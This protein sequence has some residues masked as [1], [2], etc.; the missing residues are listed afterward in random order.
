[1][2]GNVNQVNPITVPYDQARA[3][4]VA[5]TGNNGLVERYSDHRA[6]MLTLTF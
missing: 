4:A 5:A 2:K 1:M 6:H 3:A